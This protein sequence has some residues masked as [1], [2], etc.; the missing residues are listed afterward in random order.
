V[1][2]VP[3]FPGC[4]DV[5]DPRACFQEKI[6]KHI[7]KNFRY[8]QDAQE[9]GIQG[10]VSI[11]FL[12]DADGNITNIR[13]RGPDKSLEDEA[14]RII[15]R[16]PQMKPGSHHGKNVNVPFS[17]PITFKLQDDNNQNKIGFMRNWFDES[18][19]VKQGLGDRY[20]QLVIER[21]R[22]L[23]SSDEKNPVIINLDQQL[24][25]IKEQIEINTDDSVEPKLTEIYTNLI[26]ERKR[27]LQNSNERNPVIVNLNQQI[28]ALEERMQASK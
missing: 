4:E 3:M 27:L 22:L 6:Q 15:S 12:I 24:K 11:M 21:R 10:R 25:A 7:S 5:S 19:P 26:L 14:E 2:N 1:E 13:K 18:K 28:V 23:Q 16:L 17:I 20:N 9:K 8:P